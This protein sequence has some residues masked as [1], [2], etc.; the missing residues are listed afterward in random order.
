MVIPECEG[1]TESM[2]A[3]Y[4]ELLSICDAP[5]GQESIKRHQVQAQETAG[6]GIQNIRDRVAK[7]KVS[8]LFSSYFYLPSREFFVQAMLMIDKDNNVANRV[9][10]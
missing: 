6:V 4:S 8:T 7:L 5:S 1:L 9:A 2:L 3:T 10:K